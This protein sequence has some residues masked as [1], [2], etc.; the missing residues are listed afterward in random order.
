MEGAV[1]SMLSY[2]MLQQPS[3]S[4]KGRN[5]S[6]TPRGHTWDVTKVMIKGLFEGGV[7]PL[8]PH[9]SL[10][11][12]PE[13]YRTTQVFRSVKKGMG[14]VLQHKTFS[15]KFA[16]PRF[17]LILSKTTKVYATFRFKER[18]NRKIRSFFLTTHFIE[19]ATSII[20]LSEITFER[21]IINTCNLVWSLTFYE[22]SV[23][24]IEYYVLLI[25]LINK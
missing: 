14:V 5:S 12:R 15:P 10:A 18:F 16:Q 3:T 22:I 2:F 23:L 6:W 25:S 13:S 11:T 20:L 7:V 21:Q 24:N 9:H 8:R 19:R 4:S 17:I 1:L